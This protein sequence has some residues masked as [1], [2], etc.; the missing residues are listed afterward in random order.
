P[1]DERAI[2]RSAPISLFNAGSRWNSRA[3]LAQ[4]FQRE[5]LP[6]ER[7]L[8]AYVCGSAGRAGIPFATAHVTYRKL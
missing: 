7:L 8:T 4:Q 1:V 2:V 6:I 5:E 3:H